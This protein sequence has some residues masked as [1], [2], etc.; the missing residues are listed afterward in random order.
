MMVTVVFI[1]ILCWLPFNVFW[2]VENKINPEILVYL[3]F[4]FHGLAMSHA[5]YNPII[6]CY[7]NSRFRTGILQTLISIPCCRRCMQTLLAKRQKS[8]TTLPLTS[9]EGTDTTLLQRDSTYTTYVSMKRPSGTTRSTAT[10]LH[11]VPVRSASIMRTGNHVPNHVNHHP[12]HQQPKSYGYPQHV[13]E[14]QM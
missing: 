11:Q 3:W 7:M 4:A 10:S 2:I 6:Y 12:H 1:Y 9:L 14:K 5:C 8:S 13:M